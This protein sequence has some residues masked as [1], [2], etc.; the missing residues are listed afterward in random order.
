MVVEDVDPLLFDVRVTIVRS[1]GIAVG[2]YHTMLLIFGHLTSRRDISGGNA[3]FRVGLFFNMTNDLPWKEQD[4]IAFNNNNNDQG[5]IDPKFEPSL[6]TREEKTVA[7]GRRV[8]D[9]ARC[10]T[11]IRRQN[12]H[13]Y[14]ISF[15]PSSSPQ[16]RNALTLF[17]VHTDLMRQRADLMGNQGLLRMKEYALDGYTCRCHERDSLLND[18]KSALHYKIEF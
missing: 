11:S 14:V 17:N 16:H 5:P 8:I 13:S 6:D 1:D 12:T 15:E 10:H 18:E 2:K 3:L 9:E 4:A 7:T